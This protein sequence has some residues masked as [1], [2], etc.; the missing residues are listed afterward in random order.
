MTTMMG[1]SEEEDDYEDSTTTTEALTAG[2]ERMRHPR[3]FGKTIVA[4]VL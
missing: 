2:A 1:V 3:I 4:A